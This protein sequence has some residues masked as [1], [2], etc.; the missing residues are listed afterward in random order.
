MVDCFS[1]ADR[2]RLMGRIRNENS[3]PEIVVAAIV[4]RLGFRIRR[5]A[6]NLPGSPD[7]VVD[8]ARTVVFVHGCFWH[9][10]SCPRGE[11]LPE[12]RQKYWTNKFRENV[13]RD[14]RSVRALRASGWRVITAWECQTRARRRLRLEMR[15]RRLLEREKAVDPVA[16]APKAPAPKP[17][18]GR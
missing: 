10:H 7:L 1:R 12:T 17:P 8:R 11:S 2:S 16:L 5:H 14:R 6:R 13:G 9:R 4:R 18:A 3:A 15:L